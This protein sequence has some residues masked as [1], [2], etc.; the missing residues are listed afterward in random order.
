MHRG[1]NCDAA[2]VSASRRPGFMAPGACPR[3]R[4]SSWGLGAWQ[5]RPRLL[6][7]LLAGQW[8]GAVVVGPIHWAVSD[9]ESIQ[10]SVGARR[11]RLQMDVLNAAK[12]E[13]EKEDHSHAATL[14]STVPPRLSGTAPCA[15]PA[16][17]RRSP[18]S[19]G[20]RSAHLRGSPRPTR[21]LSTQLPLLRQLGAEDPRSADPRIS[22]LSQPARPS[23]ASSVPSTRAP[24]SPRAHA[25]P[26]YAGLL[27]RPARRRQSPPPPPARRRTPLSALLSPSRG[28]HRRPHV[29]RTPA[30]VPN[31]GR[32]E[33]QI[34][35]VFLVREGKK[36]TGVAGAIPRSPSPPRSYPHCA[37]SSLSTPPEEPGPRNDGGELHHR[38]LR[39]IVKRTPGKHSSLI[40][41]SM[42]GRKASCLPRPSPSPV[43]T[44]QAWWLLGPE[45]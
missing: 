8:A 24:L 34:V 43:T 15:P 16:A 42:R 30:T 23:S 39:R 3:L 21:A 14:L 28:P 36:G 9:S 1:L 20:P 40:H 41:C 6:R 26:T 25:L 2:A 35:L 17:P 38:L 10:S 31:P 37:L 7:G 12:H 11:K 13:R 4:A 5:R 44:I 22:L 32:Q 27:G 45:V 18:L 19:A 33:I 29:R